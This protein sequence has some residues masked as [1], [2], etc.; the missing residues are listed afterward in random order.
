MCGKKRYWNKYENR[1]K[2]EPIRRSKTASPSSSPL[3]FFFL[4]CFLQGIET[5]LSFYNGSYARAVMQL[6]PAIG[7]EETKF[8]YKSSMISS[9]LRS[10]SLFSSP[11][12]FF[13][14]LAPSFSCS[15]PNSVLGKHFW[16]T[17][18]NRREFLNEFSKKKEFDP[19]SPAA[20]QTITKS[21]LAS[22]S[23]WRRGWEE[24]R[25]GVGS[26]EELR[27]V[28]GLMMILQGGRYL[29]YFYGQSLER[30]VAELYPELGL[31]KHVWISSLLSS[32][33]CPSLSSSIPFLSGV[34]VDSTVKRMAMWLCG[35]VL[36]EVVRWWGGEVV[37]WWS[38][39]MVR[40]EWC[41]DVCH[42]LGT[43]Y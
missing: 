9:S 18:K 43:S 19:L 14:F 23:V 21:D 37:R 4:F 7:L 41:S 31:P 38:G 12:L 20:W 1:K 6:Y 13:C 11:L 2:E 34:A 15:L 8:L 40:W 42:A 27:E 25:R 35:E 3:L 29:L 30:A 24:V 26:S 22:V 16:R 36:S 32:F 5:I 10:P 33:V 28:N 17:A 39:E